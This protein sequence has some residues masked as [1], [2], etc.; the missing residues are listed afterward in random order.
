MCTAGNETFDSDFL[1]L[2]GQAL[3]LRYEANEDRRFYAPGKASE[4]EEGEENE[5]EEME[6]EDDETSD[7]DDDEASEAAKSSPRESWEPKRIAYF[8]ALCCI[9]PANSYSGAMMEEDGFIVP[10]FPLLSFFLPLD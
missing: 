2:I 6:E 5:G 10:H 3:D 9:S 8:L 4:P 1:Q 7:V